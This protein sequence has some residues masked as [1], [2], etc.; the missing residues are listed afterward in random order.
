MIEQLITIIGTAGTAEVS[1]RVARIEGVL[2][3]SREISEAAVQ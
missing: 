1:R 2:I 3:S